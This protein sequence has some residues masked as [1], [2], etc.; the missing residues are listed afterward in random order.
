M[1]RPSTLAPTLVLGFCL[2]GTGAEGQ[3]SA[4]ALAGAERIVGVLARAHGAL[5][6]APC[7]GESLPAA[8]HTAGAILTRELD[9]LLDRS[10][11]AIRVEVDASADAGV[12]RIGHLRRAG[13]NEPRCPREQDLGYVWRAAGQDGWRLLAT[14]RSVR[15]TG[16][17]G[18]DGRRFRFAPFVRGNDGAY[19]YA[20]DAGGEPVT[21]ELWP[22]L[23]RAS[24]SRTGE[25][26][27]SDYRAAVVWR[28]R[29]MEGCG[30]NGRA[31]D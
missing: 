28:G 10:D 27:V 11:G 6:L 17:E 5:A 29:R 3:P 14:P 25:A 24:D 23:C 16:I 21:L 15:V 12:W 1:P 8:D 26:S 9:W 31:G 18:L 2:V 22:E 19:R 4:P 7:V 30:H 13:R 20:T